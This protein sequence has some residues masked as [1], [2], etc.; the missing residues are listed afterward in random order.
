M[1]DVYIEVVNPLEVGGITK[2][3]V[4][5]TA[6]LSVESNNSIED[7]CIMIINIWEKI[8]AKKLY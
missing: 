3:N 1:D 7:C 8:N 2:Y 5:S 6:I 4:S